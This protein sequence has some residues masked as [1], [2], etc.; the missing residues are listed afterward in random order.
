LNSE[1]YNDIKTIVNNIL[2]KLPNCPETQLELQVQLDSYFMSCAFQAKNKH[3]GNK[4]L[5]LLDNL[6]DI[7]VYEKDIL[8]SVVEKRIWS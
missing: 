7:I 3:K 8:D 6:K 5:I 4:Y 2:S 1:I